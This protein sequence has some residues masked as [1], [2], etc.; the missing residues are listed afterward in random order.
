MDSY[1]RRTEKLLSLAD[2]KINGSRPSDIQV[3]NP[4]FYARVL[5]QGSLGL[6]ESY[7][8]GWWS[9]KRL[10]EF[11]AKLLGAGL[12]R[13][14]NTFGMALAAIG[15]TITNPQRT[16]KAFEIGK[17]HYDI[18][19]DL[20]SRML[21]PT[22]SYS[23]GY[24]KKA[25][26]LEEA[27][28]AKLELICQKLHLEKGMTLLDI[29]C[30]WGGLAKHAAKNYGVKVVGITV[31]KEQAAY[32]Q[33]SCKGLPV[34]IRLQDYRALD[35]SELFD[36]IVSVGMF[37]HVGVKNYRIY[38]E[39]VREHLKD[40]DGL[41]LLHTIGGLRSENTTDRWISKYIFPRSMLPSMAQITHAAEGRFVIE[42]FHN[43]GPD[44]DKTLMA[45][46][47]NFNAHWHE[48]KDMYT[49]RFPHFERMWNY[50]LLSCAGSFRARKNQL[51]QIVLSKNGVPG[52]YKPVR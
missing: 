52:G 25:K 6:G 46:N 8:E 40:D 14:V 42:D 16:S 41:F 26:N 20:Y 3:H 47:H 5:S 15:A 11:F 2:I 36:R 30:G 33:H 38:M 22:M 21:D 1:K 4:R 24:W 51:W 19:N 7:M 34:D 27:Q 31:S 43:F 37:E 28:E 13:K 18:G 32:A 9:A 50:Y 39:T 45:W 12:D 29:G 48:I 35:A 17:H 49:E 23:C 44:Y 10:D